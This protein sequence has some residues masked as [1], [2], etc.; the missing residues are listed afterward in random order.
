MAEV[1]FGLRKNAYISDGI[2]KYQIRECLGR[3]WE[4]EVYRVREGYSNGLRVLKLF[5]P[6]EYRSK[7]I[8]QYCQKLE[9][10]GSISGIIRFYHA[11]YWKKN[12][13]YYILM[14]YAQGKTLYQLYSKK[15]FPMFKGLNIIRKIFKIIN[16]CHKNK[17]CLGDLHTE[18]ILLGNDG[19]ISIIDFDLGCKF[20]QKNIKE[21]ILC[22]CKM[23]YEI[24]GRKEDYP[25]DLRD[26]IPIKKNVIAN[27]YSKVSE[28]LANLEELIGK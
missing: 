7:D 3:G 15:F 22:I 25:Q 12:D 24:T 4:G 20:T 28:V 23:F 26:V 9:R 11:G 17:F 1:K 2:V 19:E 6:A 21:D 18:N 10:L 8:L 13:C 5:N 27:K 16:E 14:E